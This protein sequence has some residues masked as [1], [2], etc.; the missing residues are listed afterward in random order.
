MEPGKTGDIQHQDP[1]RDVDLIEIDSMT[2]NH[3]FIPEG[4]AFWRRWRK[5]SAT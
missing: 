1:F 2:V 3:G 5:T 4:L